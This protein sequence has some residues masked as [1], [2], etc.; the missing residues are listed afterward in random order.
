MASKDKQLSSALGFI[1]TIVVDI[2][3]VSKTHF[4]LGN[5]SRIANYEFNV[6]R[7]HMSNN[8]S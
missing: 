3:F 7:S 5:V 8:R 1:V 6:D 2:V 4:S